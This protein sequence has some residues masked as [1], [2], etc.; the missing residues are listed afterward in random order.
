MT[1]GYSETQVLSL[2]DKPLLQERTLLRDV[3]YFARQMRL[4]GVGPAGQMRLQNAHVVVV[5]LGALG[6]PVVTYLARAGVGRV[7]LFDGDTVEYHNLHRQTLFERSDVGRR[8]AD[9]IAGYLGREFPDMEVDGRAEFLDGSTTAE[10]FRSLDADVVLDCTDRFSSRFVVHDAAQRSGV[11]LIS[12]SVSSSAGQLFLLPFGESRK[13]CLRCLYQDAPPDGC[14]GSCAEDGILGATAG[15]MGTLQALTT[16]RFL[17]NLPGPDTATVHTVDLV[18][19]EIMSI[20]WEADPK[21]LL[22]GAG[23]TEEPTQTPGTFRTETTLPARTESEVTPAGPV[24][25][26]DLREPGEAVEMDA[27]FF[28]DAEKQPFDRF[29]ETLTELD[30]RGRYLLV[31]EHGIRSRHV[32]DIMIDAGFEHVSDVAGGFAG[33][34]ERVR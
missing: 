9:V 26:I 30:R 27:F 19:L 22:C 31:C 8:K 18:G 28:P 29:L 11:Q 5:G 10:I 3:E 34:R 17:L 23:K 7:T 21:C 13:P 24:R 16:L 15:V 4:P 32:V 2:R 25:I 1:N 14:T 6:C 20:S 12:A 33:L